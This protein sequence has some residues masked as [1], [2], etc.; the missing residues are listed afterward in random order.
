V[1]LKT[2]RPEF[3]PDRAARDRFLREGTAWIELGSHPNIVRCY[4]VEYIDPTAF[5]VLELIAKEQNMP[6]A[7]LRSWL[8]LG[9][10]LPLEQAMLFAL[11]IARGMQHAT[12]RIPGFVHRDLK[13]ENVLVGADKLPETNI[14]RLR[15]TDFGL[16]KT[17]ASGDTPVTTGNIEEPKLNQVQ[18][19]RG[20]GTPHYMAPEQWKG[21]TID[22]Y[23][24]AY[25]FG[26]IL[27][28][29]LCG[30]RIVAGNTISELEVSHCKGELRPVPVNLSENIN[31]LLTKCLALKPSQRF[32]TWIEI[33]GR[34]EN[35]YTAHNGYP[36]P[37]IIST[38]DLTS[39]ERELTGWSYGAIGQAY[40]D[41]GKSDLAIEVY[42]KALKVAQE[43]KERTLESGVLNAIGASYF[44][45]G[46]MQRSIEL[47][48]QALKISQEMNDLRQQEK[49]LSNIG[50]VYF[51]LGDI[52]RAFECQMRA[53]MICRETGNRR[54][55]G[56]ALAEIGTIYIQKGEFRS[57][58]EYL[59]K[60]LISIREFG[61][62]RHEA[63]TLGNIGIIYFEL[64]DIK[65]S[66]EYAERALII[67][68]EIGNKRWEG[69]NL[70]ELGNSQLSLGNIEL[71]IGYFEQYLQVSRE[72]KNRRGEGNA[73]ASIGGA[74][75]DLGNL[76]LA[77]R[78]LEQ[79]LSVLQDVGGAMSMA[80]SC[81]RLAIVCANL[82]EKQR[83]LT[84]T[85]NAL[86]IYNQIGHSE[87]AASA[88][89]L[90]AHLQGEAD[91]E[92]IHPIQAAFEA[93]QRVNSPQEML[94][95]VK[96]Y[97]FMLEIEFI[98]LIEKVIAEQIPLTS[99]RYFEER[100]N[101]LR[102]LTSKK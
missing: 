25:A 57:G 30:K 26:C 48:E 87:K 82:G 27:Y 83:S 32:D 60:A 49:I 63:I 80:N 21:E 90:L 67:N 24:D 17:I 53:L 38:S 101:T 16:V 61:E 71:A 69:T 41:I 56:F 3:L 88:Q 62:R 92:E 31:L 6:D 11:Q 91:H 52:Q 15:V 89:K 58:L 73:L 34:L 100:L 37:K 33:V 22:V 70:H 75:L 40:Q 95:V 23:T 46:N 35:A 54:S 47:Y 81:I 97:P 84:L 64:G 2:F 51:E 50:I 14:N 77:K 12:E 10:P 7:S 8:I 59:E 98:Q 79:S 99:R 43:E 9:Q 44:H 1:A 19:T 96:Q 29:L 72:V 28:E 18:F 65:R 94:S 78:F 66:I 4:K 68:R 86:T 93:F 45:L 36:A 39:H 85:R 55:E 13:P 76:Q 102:H 42:E 20:V 74:Y 5:L